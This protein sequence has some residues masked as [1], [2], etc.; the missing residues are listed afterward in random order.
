MK[1][2]LTDE[3]PK[4]KQPLTGTN[5]TNYQRNDIDKLLTTYWSECSTKMVQLFKTV[6]GVYGY[7]CFENQVFT[8][9]CLVFD[10]SIHYVEDC[11]EN[12]LIG[13]IK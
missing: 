9:D 13:L 2:R 5:V 12:W 10:R 11:A 6:D 7:R 1:S 3:D 4:R 8:K